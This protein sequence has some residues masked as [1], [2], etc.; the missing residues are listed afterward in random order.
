[1]SGVRIGA[2]EETIRVIGGSFEQQ[3]V[4]PIRAGSGLWVR[5]GI[6]SDDGSA[7]QSYR[8]VFCMRNMSASRVL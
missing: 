2:Q 5:C 6:E 1:V 7:V 8:L 3:E 4:V